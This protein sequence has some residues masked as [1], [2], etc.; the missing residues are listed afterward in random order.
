MTII[1]LLVISNFR[2]LEQESLLKGVK[3]RSGRKVGSVG[4]VSHLPSS[5]RPQKVKQVIVWTCLGV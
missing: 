5:N 2:E 1:G 4:R 3:G